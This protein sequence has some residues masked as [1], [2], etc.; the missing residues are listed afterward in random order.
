MNE[1]IIPVLDS[2]QRGF[3]CPIHRH[4]KS[5]WVYYGPDIEWWIDGR[6]RG[7]DSAVCHAFFHSVVEHYFYILD[8][9]FR[10]IFQILFSLL[11]SGHYIKKTIL[12][13][14]LSQELLSTKATI[15]CISG[16]G[17]PGAGQYDIIYVEY[18][19]LEWL[20]DRKGKLTVADITEFREALNRVK[21]N[22]KQ[23]NEILTS[24]AE[25]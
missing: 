22:K 13:C 16:A 3:A 18:K 2:V 4:D 8:I 19:F 7:N 20:V 12:F 10:H 9:F 11:N 15:S 1:Q 6:S 23:V 21:F 5:V 14:L 25:K 17:V 24:I